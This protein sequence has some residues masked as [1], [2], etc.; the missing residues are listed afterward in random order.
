MGSLC[1]KAI[2]MDKLALLMI[3]GGFILISFGQDSLLSATTGHENVESLV[4]HL[5]MK[6]SQMMKKQ[7]EEIKQLQEENK[8]QYEDINDMQI[9][10][11]QHQEHIINLQKENQ[12]NEG[13]MQKLQRENLQQK[14]KITHLEA[15]SM[16]CSQE[17]LSKIEEQ[18]N[19]VF[20]LTELVDSLNNKS[21][22]HEKSINVLRSPPAVYFC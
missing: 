19:Q 5:D 13:K 4:N 17:T 10:I 7:Q 14:E 21:F 22:D 6:F 1:W 16:K 11:K 20:S 15:D 3:M 12:A 18:T 9:T 2:S 8:N